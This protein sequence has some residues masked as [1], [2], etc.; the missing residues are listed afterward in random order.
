MRLASSCSFVFADIINQHGFVLVRAWS[1]L[2][3]RKTRTF[4]YVRIRDSAGLS[5]GF[6]VAESG[7]L[8]ESTVIVLLSD[9]CLLSVP[10]RLFAVL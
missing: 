2:E 3:I 8:D 6:S 5:V 4:T 10:P 7:F 9:T 1:W